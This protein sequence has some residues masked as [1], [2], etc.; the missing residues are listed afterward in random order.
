MNGHPLPVLPSGVRCLPLTPHPDA[1]GVFLELFRQSWTS[2]AMPAQWNAVR[3]EG[4]VLR[5]VHAHWRHADYVVALSGCMTVGLKDLRPTSPTRGMVA[6]IELDGDA[7]RGL[8]IPQG[9]AH[10]FYFPAPALHVYAVSHYWDPA[11]ELGCRWDDPALGIAWPCRSPFVSPKDQSLP[12][13]ATLVGQMEE[14]LSALR[15]VR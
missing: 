13:L 4:N 3:S 5:G 10:G 8:E 7:P 1:R 6:R 15:A 14:R 2:G 11:D 9:V 12:D